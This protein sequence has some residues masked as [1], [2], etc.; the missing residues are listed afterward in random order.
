MTTSHIIQTDDIPQLH[1]RKAGQ[2]PALVLIHG[3]PES[4]TLWDGVYPALAEKHTVLMPDLP[5]AGQSM[6]ATQDISMEQM[7][8]GVFAIL[9]TENIERAI[10]LGHSMGGYVALAFAEAYG[11]NLQGLGLIHSTA[12]ADN[13]EKIATRKKA[14][15]LIEKEGGREAFIKQMV[16]ALFSPAYKVK[17]PDGITIQ[18]DRGLEL[19][20]D[21]MIAFYNAM[22]NRSDRT[23]LLKSL[24]APVLWILGEQDTTIPPEGVLQQTSLSSVNFV[25]LYED[26]GHMSMLEQPQRLIT[27][28][29]DF[30]AYCYGQNNG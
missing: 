27:D 29:L 18:T 11:D 24:K 30:S 22:I 12:A 5:G 8:M 14:I 20:G 4:G 17:H 25:E 26:C 13:D 23:E 28:I 1:Y 6:I 19:S 10:V 2:G 16:P 3:F 9:Q 7:A 21:S 15:V